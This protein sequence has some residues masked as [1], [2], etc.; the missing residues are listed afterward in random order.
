MRKKATEKG[1]SSCEAV[2]MKIVWDEDGDLALKKLMEELRTKYKKDYARTTVA[3]FL[4]R[5]IEK[6]YVRTYRVG[7]VSFTHALKKEKDYVDKMLRDQTEF[8]FK[9]DATKMLEAY[10]RANKLTDEQKEQ[11]KAIIDNAE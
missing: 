8:W 7:R 4:Q 11:M 2:I 1:L 5:L 9:G 6:G 3:T 10:C